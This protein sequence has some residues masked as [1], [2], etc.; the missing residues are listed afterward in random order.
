M[1]GKTF[2]EHT[3]FSSPYE[4]PYILLFSGRPKKN[5]ACKHFH[6]VL[7]LTKFHSN[8]YIISKMIDLA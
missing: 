7:I 1:R 6:F 4:S 3:L 2:I 8:V 5:G